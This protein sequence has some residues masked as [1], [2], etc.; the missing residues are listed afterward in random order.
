MLEDEHLLVGAHN[1]VLTYNRL[2]GE[3]IMN[4]KI[5]YLLKDCFFMLLESSIIMLKPFP[6][7]RG[8]SPAVLTR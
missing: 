4:K 3:F 6:L 5:I 1:F 8:S 7:Y 2:L